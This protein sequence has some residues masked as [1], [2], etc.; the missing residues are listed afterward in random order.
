MYCSACGAKLDAGVAFCSA[1]GTP[2][3]D[4]PAAR[5][6]ER[7][8]R[9]VR[10]ALTVVAVAVIAGVGVVAAQ[11]VDG[12]IFTDDPAGRVPLAQESR[13]PAPSPAETTADS[14]TSPPTSPPA[15]EDDGP[16]PG[17]A[18][19]YQEVGPG[20]VMVRA[21]TC[22]GTGVGS[23]FLVS[24]DEVVTAAHVV[25]GAASVA[26]VR[27]DVIRQ[28]T[29]IGTDEV[30]D[31]AVLE[32]A[33]ELDGHAF[34]FADTDVAAG[35]ALAV[36]GHPLGDPL[37]I[38][39]GTAS[40]VDASLWP[41]FQLD[42]SVSPGNSGGP[43]V[44]AD[45]DVVGMV[46]AKDVEADGLA[47]A[48]RAEVIADHLDDRSSFS[49]PAVAACDEPLGPPEAELPD[50]DEAD[51]L[52]AAII[53]TFAS[54]FGGINAGEYR[55]A[56]DQLSPRLQGGLSA[57]EFAEG[58]VTSYDFDFELFS[59]VETPTGAEVWLEFVS[60]QAPEYGPDGEACTNW[61]LDYELTWND[62]GWLL[63][64]RVTGHGDTSGHAPCS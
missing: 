19:L 43:V 64:D 6:T 62:S 63:I 61:S 57:S 47:Y 21:T 3:S 18:E 20:V 53:S 16:A 41:S 48:I 5:R 28:A 17:F 22:H 31:I 14:P 10:V 42:A 29:V 54:Y 46:V 4:H 30:N 7:H 59:V 38:T 33:G 34:G 12:G 2:T 26:V 39:A 36:I 58:V 49:D 1:C 40:R 35:E 24:E 27:D 52:E 56:F 50:I 55:L 8:S 51:E 44:R 15:A 25:E 13:S 23:A 37:T 45:G 60:L 9:P 11:V 32:L